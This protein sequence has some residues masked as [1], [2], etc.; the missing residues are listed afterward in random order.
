MLASMFDDVSEDSLFAL[1]RENPRMASAGPVQQPN[2]DALHQQTPPPQQ[3]SFQTAPAGIP[4]MG[5]SP[6]GIGDLWGF[7]TGTPFGGTIPAIEPTDASPAAAARSAGFTALAATAAIGGGIA[8]GG[9]WG[10]AAGGFLVGALTNAYRTQKWWGSNDP[11]EKHEA[12]VSGIMSL[13]G[14]GLGGFAGYKAFQARA[15]GDVGGD[16]DDDDDDD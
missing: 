15:D 11:S 5:A 12:V 13:V 4:S 3:Q 2:H 1:E 9:A 7:G 16:D 10:G 14:L 8:A 6:D